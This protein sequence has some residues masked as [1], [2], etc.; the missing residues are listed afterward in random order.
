MAA[1]SSASAARIGNMYQEHHSWLSVFIKRRLGCPEA[2]AD[3]VQD[4]Y[5]R[6]LTR[7]KLPEAKD[8]RRY[9]THIAKG[10]VIDLYR[11]R[12][13]EA[14]YLELIEQEPVEVAGSPEDQA[15]IVQALVEID[16]LLHR[17]PLKAR[18]ALL[19]R[20]LE[21]KS[22]KEIALAL[23]VSV[24]SVEKYVAKALQGCMMT[25]LSENE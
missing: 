13:I 23:D 22:Y 21:G 5:L 20:Q 17:L 14:A 24:S 8:S 6:L 15:V 4:T 18:Q 12:R 1:I 2:T 3:L 16:A 7:G 10:L 25:M 9:L 19:M 11:R